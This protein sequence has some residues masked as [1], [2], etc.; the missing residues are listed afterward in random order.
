M[1]CR[2]QGQLLD[3]MCD[4][5]WVLVLGRGGVAALPPS[6]SQVLGYGKCFPP[7]AAG[8]ARWAMAML[9]QKGKSLGLCSPHDSAA[10]DG[11]TPER[12]CNQRGLG[13]TTTGVSTMGDGSF[14]LRR[15]LQ[16]PSMLIPPRHVQISLCVLVLYLRPALQGCPSGLFQSLPPPSSCD[17]WAGVV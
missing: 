15:P 17:C 9:F 13:L 2:L 10:H 12:H 8:L 1:P 6:W 7:S 4:G 16:G 3:E 14:A 5:R 11:Q